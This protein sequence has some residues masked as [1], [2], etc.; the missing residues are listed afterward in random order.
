[1]NHGIGTI[2]KIGQMEIEQIIRDVCKTILQEKDAKKKR[3]EALEAL[4][5]YYKQ[6]VKN[7][8]KKGIGSNNSLP[9]FFGTTDTEPQFNP[10]TNN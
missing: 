7:A 5:E 4:G 10:N 1:M 8:K 2:W 9:F 6:E 3:A